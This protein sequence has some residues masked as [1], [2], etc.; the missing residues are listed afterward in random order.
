LLG[1]R[2]SSLLELFCEDIFQGRI[3][4]RQVRMHTLE[5]AVFLFEFFQPSDVRRLPPPSILSFPLVVGG[6]V[7][8]ELSAEGINRGAGVGLSDGIHNLIFQ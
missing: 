6:G 7:D 1:A 4:Q 8:A 2:L 5:T 3:L